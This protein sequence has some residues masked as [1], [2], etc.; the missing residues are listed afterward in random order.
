MLCTVLSHRVLVNWQQQ[1][2]KLRYSITSMSLSSVVTLLP[3]PLELKDSRMG[4]GSQVLS[5]VWKDRF[6]DLRKR[7]VHQSVGPDEMNPTVLRELAGVAKPLSM[8]LKSHGSQVKSQ[9]TGIG[10]TLYHLLKRQKG[11]FWELL[12]CQPHLYTW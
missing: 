10:I 3:T 11:E 1:M 8:T 4:K 2:R 7:N 9:V 6:H 5:T 12:I